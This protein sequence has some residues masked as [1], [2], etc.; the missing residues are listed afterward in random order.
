MRVILN[1]KQPLHQQRQLL[2]GGVVPVSVP[3]SLLQ[4][5]LHAL[6]ALSSQFDSERIGLL[7]RRLGLVGLVTL[8]ELQEVVGLHRFADSVVL[9]HHRQAQH[10][11][12]GSDGQLKRWGGAYENSKIGVYCVYRAAHASY[13]VALLLLPVGD[14]LHGSQQTR[15]EEHEHVA[16]ALGQLLVEERRVQLVYEVVV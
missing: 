11:T 12:D 13:G 4:V 8:D 14:V 15:Q 3:L 10:S 5:L 9:V 6:D 7:H 16:D 2:A 1:R